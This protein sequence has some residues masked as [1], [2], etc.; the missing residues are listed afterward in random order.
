MKRSILALMLIISAS[1]IDAKVQN[2]YDEVFL[3]ITFTDPTEDQRPI[4]KESTIIPS[5]SLNEHTLLFVTLCD[6]CTLR[7]INE[8]KD[9]EYIT[10]IPIGTTTLILPPYLSGEY[11]LQIIR[12]NYCFWA[13]IDL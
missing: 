10:V 4:K 3:Q 8:D 5:V 11:Q 1:L 9:V 2:V 7:L 6:G 12:G 13:Y